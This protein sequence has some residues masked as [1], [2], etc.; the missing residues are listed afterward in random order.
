VRYLLQAFFDAVMENEAR[1]NF[2]VWILKSTLAGN[3]CQA[4]RIPRVGCR[5]STVFYILLFVVSALF[6]PG[7]V[8][9]Q[10]R[11]SFATIFSLPKKN[12]FFFVLLQRTRGSFL[13]V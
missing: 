11:F 2:T 10:A 3:V 4:T 7:S 1:P 9:L 5:P 6:L 12:S 8:S 13:C